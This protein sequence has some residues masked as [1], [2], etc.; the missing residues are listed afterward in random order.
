AGAFEA[1]SQ[2]NR[3][4]QAF[5]AWVQKGADYCGRIRDLAD[6]VTAPW[7][8]KLSPLK[9]AS[10]RSPAF[11]VGFPRSGTTLLDTFLMGHPDTEVLEEFHMLGAAEA[12]LGNIAH[13]PDRTPEELEQARRAYFVELDRHVDRDFGGLIVDKLPLNIPGLPG[14]PRLVR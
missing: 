5:N 1:A 13:L 3:S 10:R 8:G 11:L 14:I 4:V 9:P 6:T 7:A 12:M 2:M